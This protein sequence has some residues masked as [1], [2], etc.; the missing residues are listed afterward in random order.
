M[1]AAV[2]PR[3]ARAIQAPAIESDRAG[4]AD[5]SMRRHASLRCEGQGGDIRRAGVI[6]AGL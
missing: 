2:R 6:D 5:G 3:N 4:A 1:A